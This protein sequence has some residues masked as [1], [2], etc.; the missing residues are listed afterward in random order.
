M[1]D[2]CVIANKA[3]AQFLRATGAARPAHTAVLAGMASQLPLNL[4][5]GV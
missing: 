5:I 1:K 4:K 3:G 2:V